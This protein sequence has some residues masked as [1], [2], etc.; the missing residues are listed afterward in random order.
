MGRLRSLSR[1]DGEER[2]LT[3]RAHI[4][5]P[6]ARVALRLVPFTVVRRF[7][8][9][10]RAPAVRRGSDWPAAVRRSM[11]RAGRS[12]PGS[13]CLARSLAAEVLLRLGGHPARLT[14]GVASG[15]ASGVPL[16]AHAWVESG[17]IVVAGEGELDKY[18]AIVRF[19]ANA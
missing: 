15:G 12:L 5:L 10:R 18:T 11:V 1:L 9:A 17:G 7:V 6:L 3:I 14:I 2:A 16:D 13:S 19:G 8:E 4:W